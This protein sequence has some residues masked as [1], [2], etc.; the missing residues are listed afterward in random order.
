MEG[1][2]SSASSP[3]PSA[4]P[5]P[6][7]S[8]SS[9]SGGRIRRT[10][11][12]VVDRHKVE[13]DSSLSSVDWPFRSSLLH[14]ATPTTLP[15]PKLLPSITKSIPKHKHRQSSSSSIRRSVEPVLKLYRP[16]AHT[17]HLR[18]GVQQLKFPSSPAP[19]FNREIHRPSLLPSGWFD[20]TMY[21]ED[22]PH[23]P[24]RCCNHNSNN[25]NN[26]SNNNNIDNSNYNN[27]DNNT[28][29]RAGDNEALSCCTKSKDMLDNRLNDEMLIEFTPALKAQCEVK[30]K[31]WKECYVI[32]FDKIEELYIAV[33][34]SIPDKSVM[35]DMTYDKDILYDEQTCKTI[36]YN[37]YNSA[38]STRTTTGYVPFHIGKKVSSLQLHFDYESESQYEHRKSEA[39]RHRDTVE[40]ALHEQLLARAVQQQSIDEGRKGIHWRWAGAESLPNATL[41]N[42]YRKVY[43]H[44]MVTNNNC[45]SQTTVDELL[46][47]VNRD[48]GL[49][50]A[51]S[52]IAVASSTRPPWQHP[53]LSTR[54]H[55]RRS[56]G[57]GGG[58]LQLTSQSLE[59]YRRYYY[60][61]TAAVNHA[62]SISTASHRDDTQRRSCAD[63]VRV[64]G[65][66]NSNGQIISNHKQG[67]GQICEGKI[68]LSTSKLLGN[69]M[70]NHRLRA[71]FAVCQQVYM[72]LACYLTTC[73]LTVWINIC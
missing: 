37:W 57:E 30:S 61:T 66:R 1:F 29:S 39:I 46:A 31:Q 60:Q 51:R 54:G 12:R 8:V 65:N 55:E 15:S 71:V 72:A 26:S 4:P 35:D 14:T 47:E 22:V 53:L 24:N 40:L 34:R 20:E 7:L 58:S 62:S 41:G 16:E 64:E 49:S 68:L 11:C 13:I 36:F 70:M 63:V 27:K 59:L 3:R 6:P 52:S 32:S 2:H 44:Q 43:H 42:V 23:N 10:L 56:S 38:R 28:S 67:L 19:I 5:P 48:Y 33:W 73:L 18:H 9:S 69:D 50:Q 17:R 45:N 25:N 21:S